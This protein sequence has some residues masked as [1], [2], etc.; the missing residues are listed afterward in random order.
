MAGEIT[1]L[2]DGTEYPATFR[3]G[4]ALQFKELTGHEV[5]EIAP[6]SLTDTATLMYCC[7]AAGARASGKDFGLTLRQFADSVGL[8]TLSRWAEAVFAKPEPGGEKKT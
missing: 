8:D 2:V 6:D 7:V 1:I 3:L 4:A 5:G